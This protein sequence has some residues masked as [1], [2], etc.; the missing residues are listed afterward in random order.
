M[1]LALR[2]RVCA[3]GKHSCPAATSLG[4]GQPRAVGPLVDQLGAAD[5]HGYA[6]QRAPVMIL[7]DCL[8]HLLVASAPV[9]DPG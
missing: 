5:G 4:V 8:A 6:G 3:T 2:S 7:A 1:A 9:A